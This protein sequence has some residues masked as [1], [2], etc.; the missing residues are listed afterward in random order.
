MPIARLIITEAAI[1]MCNAF[2]R[3]AVVVAMVMLARFLFMLLRQPAR[4]GPGVKSR[5]QRYWYAAFTIRMTSSTRS[6]VGFSGLASPDVVGTAGAGSVIDLTS[7]AMIGRRPALTRS[8]APGRRFFVISPPER[9][10]R[11]VFPVFPD[12][13]SAPR[14]RPWANAQG[15]ASW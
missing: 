4:I 11:Q 2:A 10:D 9:P 14:S 3:V 6:S 5:P 1:R 13:R 7:G 8:P 12:R 15:T